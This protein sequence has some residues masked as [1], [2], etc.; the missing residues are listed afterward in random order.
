MP[1]ATHTQ[2]KN[3][4]ELSNAE[5]NNARAS[6]KMGG[7][8][9]MNATKH[10]PAPA[11][12][13]LRWFF[14]Y[15][16]DAGISRSEAAT[17]VKVDPS[18]I[19]RVF[20]GTYKDQNKKT[21]LPKT[22]ITNIQS[23]RRIEGQRVSLGDV[24]FVLTPTAATI[25]KLCDLAVSSNRIAMIWGK[26]QTGKTTALLE[27]KRKHN[28]GSTKYIRIEPSSG[29]HELMRQIGK[30]CAL[31][32]RT[33]YERL[34][35]RVVRA[36]DRNTLLIVDEIHELTFTYRV[37]SKLSC[38]EVLRWLHDTTRCGM[39]ICGTNIWRD[40]LK[41]GKDKLLL[42]Q[43]ERRGVFKRQLPSEPTR[44]DLKAIFKKAFTLDWPTGEAAEIIKEVN[45]K[46]GLTAITEYLRYGH[47]LAIKAEEPLCWSHF[48][49]AY[50]IISDL[51]TPS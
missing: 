35:D 8:Q 43:M 13:A 48:M 2:D 41:E 1:K 31:S 20:M 25:W 29:I 12:D 9:I 38:V 11:R 39:V 47:R 50:A 18:T 51:E 19:Y 36:V 3:E 7:D 23:F 10:Y 45:T 27:Y 49:K 14:F 40:E 33:S 37:R 32:P 26:S 24:P 30:E 22:L 4:E 42:E 44:A 17:L 21:I 46:Q 28:H 16:I 6:W 15:C 34:K 5:G